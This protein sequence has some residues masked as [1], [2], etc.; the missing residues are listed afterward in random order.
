M[1][2]F[3][4]RPPPPEGASIRRH[5][6]EKKNAGALAHGLT[7]VYVPLQSRLVRWKVEKREG[8]QRLGGKQKPEAAEK[9]DMVAVSLPPCSPLPPPAKSKFLSVFLVKPDHTGFQKVSE[10]RNAMPDVKNSAWTVPVVANGKLYLR[11]LQRL[12]C[13]NP[14]P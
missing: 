8:R 4:C 14:L 9:L 1:R 7:R 10:I 5:A 3:G 13:Y 2:K 12:I 6:G 11:H